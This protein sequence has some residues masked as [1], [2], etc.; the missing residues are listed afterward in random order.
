VHRRVA[1]DVVRHDLVAA[2]EQLHRLEQTLAAV[3]LHLITEVEGRDIPTTQFCRGTAAWLRSQ[4]L[5]DPATARQ[6]T[7]LA[8]AVRRHPA[9]DAA[10]CA[11]TIQARQAAAICEALEALPSGAE[12]AALPAT[13]GG[14]G[15][16]DVADGAAG[17]SD[18]AASAGGPGGAAALARCLDDVHPPG[19]VVAVEVAAAAEAALLKF[20]SDYAPAALRRLGARILDHVAP[21]VADRL[22]A[23]ALERAERRAWC[24]R[25]LTLSRRSVG[26]C[27]SAGT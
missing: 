27:E 22:D 11:G 15:M 24:E 21:Q 19:E 8:V 23:V 14:D 7:D 12:L 13:V 17:F 3:Q 26:W 2:V 5:L 18:G 10:L 1:V 20:A 9:V 25:G 16:A 4:L 6:L